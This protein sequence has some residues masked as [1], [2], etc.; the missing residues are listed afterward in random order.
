MGSWLASYDRFPNLGHNCH[1]LIRFIGYY[2]IVCINILYRYVHDTSAYILG[3]LKVPFYPNV[4]HGF[5]EVGTN[6]DG[7]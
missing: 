1:A 2:Y 6:L 3:L 4:L 7:I 5:L